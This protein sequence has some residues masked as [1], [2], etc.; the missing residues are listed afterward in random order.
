MTK[1]EAKAI[2]DTCEPSAAQ[3]LGTYTYGAFHRADG[4]TVNPV[5]DWYKALKKRKITSSQW[6]DMKER[7]LSWV[8]C[9]CGNQCAIIPRDII[10]HNRVPSRPLDSKLYKLGDDFANAVIDEDVKGA[11]GL[12]DAI[13]LR[14]AE[15]IA[16]IKGIKI[17]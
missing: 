3:K 10:P 15:L 8:T 7:S 4:K 16:E 5:F 9:A 13:E 17:K 14:S 11:L 1:E 6:E 12:L 2:L